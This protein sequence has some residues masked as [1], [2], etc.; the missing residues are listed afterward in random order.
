MRA[1]QVLQQHQLER[2]SA[3]ALERARGHRLAVGEQA[4]LARLQIG[5]E[6][7]P[8]AHAERHQH[9]ADR[10]LFGEGCAAVYGGSCPAVGTAAT[11]ANDAS[12][13]RA[14]ETRVEGL[15]GMKGRPLRPACLQQSGGDGNRACRPRPEGRCAVLATGIAG[16]PRQTWVSPSAVERSAMSSSDSPAPAADTPQVF[17]DRELSWLAFARRVLALVGDARSAAARAAQVRRH[18]GALHDEFFMKRMSGLQ[19]PDS[20]RQAKPKSARR[21]APT[22]ELLAAC[23]AE[24]LDQVRDARSLAARR[25]AARAGR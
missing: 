15:P 12:R 6:A 25:P 2:A 20:S 17:F 9:P 4:D 18:H 24:I 8:V 10:H 1:R 19:A 13:W 5:D 7:A 11:N 14:C 23:R 21:A 16:V 3:A 22:T